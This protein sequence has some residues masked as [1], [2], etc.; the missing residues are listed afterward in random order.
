MLS[1]TDESD[2]MLV[3]LPHL[4]D[5]VHC[6]GLIF[7]AV[8]NGVKVFVVG[9]SACEESLPRGYD[10][11]VIVE[12]F[13]QSCELLGVEEHISCKMKVRNF[14]ENRQEIL[15]IIRTQVNYFKPTVVLCPASTDN[16]QDHKVVYEEVT[17]LCKSQVV[18]GYIHVPNMREIRPNV[19]VRITTDAMKTKVGCWQRYRSQN[20]KSGI[21]D[22]AFLITSCE[23][24]GRIAGAEYAEP[25]EWIGGVSY[26]V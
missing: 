19:L 13:R 21:I 20:E 6:A 14:P 26:A 2:R 9:L 17:R 24:W 25:Y 3:V 4:D 1:F 5:E 16:H 11:S 10:R 22:S 23:Y 18:V 7:D 12:E 8:R 15:N